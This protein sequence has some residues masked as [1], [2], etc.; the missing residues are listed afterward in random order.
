MRRRRRSLPLRF[1]PP[2]YEV[3]PY[4][5]GIQ[6]DADATRSLPGD[7]FYETIQIMKH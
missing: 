5:G 4:V 6:V 1:G 3:K 2:T 7:Q